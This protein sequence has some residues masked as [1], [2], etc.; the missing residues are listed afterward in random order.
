MRVFVVPGHRTITSG[1]FSL[2]DLCGATGRLDILLRC[3]NSAFFLSNGIRDEVILYLVLLGYPEPPKTLKFLGNEL[4][5]LNPDERSTGA[6]VRTALLKKIDN[7]WIKS[8][9]GIYISQKKFEDIIKEC[10]SNTNELIYLKETGVNIKDMQLQ[11]P[12]VVLGD[13][14]DLT[15]DEEKVLTELGA[16]TVSLGPRSL[17]SDHCITLVNNQM[18]LNYKMV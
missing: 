5:Y 7:N 11:N 15:L 3:I 1:D 2:N 12:V 10:V 4:K 16:K 13:Q 18:D 9:P 6:L 17:H 8:T 14:Y